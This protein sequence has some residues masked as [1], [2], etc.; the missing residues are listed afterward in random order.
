MSTSKTKPAIVYALLALVVVIWGFN[1]SFV[2]WVISQVPPL[3]FTAVRLT[4]ASGLILIVLTKKEGWQS[5]P[6]SDVVKMAALGILGHSIYQIFFINGI[7]LTTAG[8][9]SLLIATSPIWTA[10]ISGVL[11]KDEVTIRAWLGIILAFVGVFLVTVGGEGKLSFAGAKTTGDLLTISAALALSL[12]TVLSRDLLE[13]YSPLR[14]TAITMIF[15]TGGLWIFAGRKVVAQN[16]ASLSLTSWGVIVYSAI[17]AVVVG[18]IIWFTAVRTIGPTRAAVFNNM[19]PIVAF[20]VAFI[21]LGEP[22]SWLQA[23]GGITV[24]SGIIITVRN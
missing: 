13:R 22:V 6:A 11:K 5:M 8:N 23:V 16:W 18:Y 4:I 14:L 12:Y 3:A 21:L 20:T 10:L 15:G 19:T 9:S 7:S 2:K 17:F 1:F 24:I